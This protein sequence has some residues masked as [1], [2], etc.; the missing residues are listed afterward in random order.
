MRHL[1]LLGLALAACEGPPGP[2]GPA[3]G[4][5]DG[6][7]GTP[8]L[9]GDPAPPGAWVAGAGVDLAITSFA[10]DATGATVSFTL[11]DAGGGALD[12]T[13]HL[14]AGKVDLGFVVAQ[15][16]NNADGSAGQYT[17][18]TTRQVT[19]TITNLTATQATTETVEANFE[20][21]DVT[22]GT[23]RYKLAAPLTG[24]DPTKTQ[25]VAAFATRTFGGVTTFDREVASARPDGGAVGARE[26]VTE[27]TC[28]ACHG[29]SLAAHG[30]RWTSPKQCVLCH[31]PQSSDPDTGNTVDFKIML[32][33][34]HRGDEL[35]SVVAGTPYQVIGFGGSV[36]DYST[37]GFPQNIGR[38]E[39]CHAGTQADRWS[40]AP[41]IE[42]CTSCHDTTSFVQPVPVGKVLHSGG[43]QTAGTPCNV[44]HPSAGGLAG[45][46]DTHYTGLLAANATTVALELQ[47]IT[48]TGPGQQPVLRFRALVDGAPRN[49][50]TAPLTRLTATLAGPTTDFAGY[51][52]ATIQGT[53]ATGVLTAVD[54]AN[55]V[56]DYAFP[57]TA[58]IPAT[59][60]GSYEV[61]L[62]GY[63][64]PLATDPRYAA[65]SPIL[66]FAVTDATPQP[67]RQI[68][69]AMKC[70]GC[71]FDLAGHGGSRKNPAYCVT[72][73]NPNKAND[74]RIAR[75]EGSTVQA[76]SVDF[77]VMIHKI[78][79]G[80]EL[81]Q[82]YV[83]GG[84]P[85]PTAANPAG[86]PINFGE[87]RYP[88]TRTDCAACHTSKNW[89]L[90]MNRSSAYR[91]ST[92]LE[93]T[94]S[95]PAGADANS[96][97]DA[98]FWTV[99]ATTKI[100][101]QASVCTSCHDAPDTAAHALVNT[102]VLGAESC[103]TCH[104]DG[105]QWDVSKFHGV[106]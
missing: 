69:D 40:T 5:S 77:R 17:A 23:Y 19:S 3:G 35:P 75:F 31:Q 70:N 59:A 101:P 83:L 55:G 18:Y 32:H 33:K 63:V 46:R 48:S 10:I 90:P 7:P 61:G 11:K 92:A 20:V 89:T 66:P 94:C 34:I 71:H 67:R 37:V 84:F 14:T 1:L 68:V 65:F 52:Q 24:L 105:K 96:Y 13:G 62:E 30:G 27:Q 102:T 41:S 93:L 28:G 79:R 22:A 15:L 86:T 73:H 78:H 98:P 100:A 21:V 72:C 50:S 95:E 43:A 2:P 44:C 97:C 9:P 103:A 6:V 91:P 49:L 38:C 82:P 53:G 29:T 57:A 99:T 76:E 16:A 60:T 87:T 54:A 64:Q 74:E 85:A 25:T 88:R 4:G 8:G 45:I 51:W 42:T 36:H 26:I 106:P 58:I 47:T 104:G 80:E 81:S 12:R 56:F 39:A